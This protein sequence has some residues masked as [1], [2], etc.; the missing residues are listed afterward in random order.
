MSYL[1][2]STRY[3]GYDRRFANGHYRFYRDHDLLESKFGPVTSARWTHVR[4]LRRT[5]ADS[6]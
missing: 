3:L 1:E 5:A 2:Q 4:H 6:Y